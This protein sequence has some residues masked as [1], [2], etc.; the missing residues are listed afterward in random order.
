MM[1]LMAGLTSSDHGTRCNC[2]K[3]IEN[4]L[5]NFAVFDLIDCTLTFKD[6]YYAKLPYLIVLATLN[7]LNNDTDL[8]NYL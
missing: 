2:M 8:S 3:F 7:V 5:I 6:Q 4:E 1:V